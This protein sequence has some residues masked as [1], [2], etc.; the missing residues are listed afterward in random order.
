VVKR[1]FIYVEGGGAKDSRDDLRRALGEF[2][3]QPRESARDRN[4][5]WRLVMCGSRDAAYRAF[6]DS[7][8][9]HPNDYVFLLVD[10]EQATTGTPRQHLSARDHWD[11]SWAKEAQCHLMAQVMESWFLADPAALER[12]YGQKFGVGQIPKRRNVEEVPKDEVISALN[13]ASQSTSAGRY[14]KIHHGAPILE[15][16]DPEKVRTRAPHCNRLFE[17]LMEAIG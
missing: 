5:P 11:L 10:A 12:F 9:Q 8:R 7:A 2:L 16:L 4:I 15:S 6:R 1:I 13:R 14:H 3:S 17:T